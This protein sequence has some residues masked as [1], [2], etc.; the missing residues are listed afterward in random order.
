MKKQIRYLRGFFILLLLMA[1]YQ[2]AY[3]QSIV[4]SDN[5]SPVIPNGEKLEFKIKL[6]PGTP[7]TNCYL[8]AYA[9]TGWTFVGSSLPA[10]QQINATGDTIKISFSTLSATTDISIYLRPGC[11]I[12]DKSQVV[13]EFFDSGDNMLAQTATPDIS[14][15]KY[16]VIVQN[17]PADT[18]M[19]LGAIAYREWKLQENEQSA[20]V[21]GGDLTIRGVGNSATTSSTNDKLDLLILGVEYLTKDS[22]WQPL[23]ATIASDQKSY[24]YTFTSEDFK[25]IGN[26]DSILSYADGIIRIREKVQLSRC[27]TSSFSSITVQP[28]LTYSISHACSQTKVT[29]GTS[30]VTYAAPYPNSPISLVK[31]TNPTQAENMGKTILKL[32]NINDLYYEDI[33]LRLYDNDSYIWWMNIQ[34][35]YFSD[36]NGNI[37]ASA[38]AITWTNTTGDTYLRFNSTTPYKGLVNKTPGDNICDD[39][40]KSSDPIYITLDWYLDLDTKTATCT[41]G[42]S[43]TYFFSMYPY[44][45]MYYNQSPNC[46]TYRTSTSTYL[47][48]TSSTNNY[49]NLGFTAGTGSSIANSNLMYYPEAE[50]PYG[51]RTTITIM[52]APAHTYPNRTFLNDINTYKHTVSLTLPADLKY[53]PDN[54]VTISGIA[55]DPDS[56]WYDEPTRTLTFVNR[57]KA[58]TSTLSYTFTVEPVTATNAADKSVKVSHTID[59]GGTTYR[60]GCYSVPLSYIIYIP[61]ECNYIV[62]DGFRAERT[63][64]GY[65]ESDHSKQMTLAEAHAAGARLDIIGPYDNVEFEINA[66]IKGDS[67]WYYDADRPLYA[68]ISYRM[69]QTNPYFGK[70]QGAILEYKRPGETTWNPAISIPASALIQSYAGTVHRLRVDILPYL[71]SAGVPLLKDTRFRVT[72]LSQATGNLPRVMEGVP[73]FEMGIYADGRYVYDCNIHSSNLFVFDYRVQY[74]TT[75]TTGDNPPTE[76]FWANGDPNHNEIMLL[77]LHM[78]NLDFASNEIFTNEFRPN[79][80]LNTFVWRYGYGTFVPERIW[81]SEGR[82][83]VKDVDYTVT[84]YSYY[85][86]ITFKSDLNALMGEY[87][88]SKDDFATDPVGK[89][90]YY[91]FATAKQVCYYNTYSG[92]SSTVSWY[93]TS[94]APYRTTSPGGDSD[95]YKARSQYQWSISTTSTQSDQKTGSNKLSWPLRLT[96]SSTW[97]STA[98]GANYFMPN[99]YLFL[100]VFSGRLENYELYRVVGGIEQ[101]VNAPFEKYTSGSTDAATG[102][103]KEAYWIKIGNI[104][105]DYLSASSCTAD[106]VLKAKYPDC[107]SSDTI[108]NIKLKAKF[109]VNT[110]EY[111]ADPWQGWTKYAATSC[112]HDGA[113]LALTSAFYAMDFSGTVDA[114]AKMLPGGKF[115]LCDTIPFK[116]SYVNNLYCP[117]GSLEFKVHR[118]SGSSLVLHDPTLPNSLYYMK[119]GT[120]VSYDPSTWFIDESNNDYILIKLPE[121]TILDARPFDILAPI[122]GAQIDL[123]VNLIPTCDFLFGLPIYM[124]V[125]GSS[126]CGLTE[127]KSVATDNIR[128]FG[129]DESNDPISSV[130]VKLNDKTSGAVLPYLTDADGQLKLKGYFRFGEDQA[131]NKASAYIS[132]PPNTRLKSGGTNTFQRTGGASGSSTSFTA[133]TQN[134]LRASFA[135]GESTLTQYDYEVDLEAIN[136]EKWDCREKIITMG[137]TVSVEQKCHPEDLTPCNVNNSIM[138]QQFKFTMQK[139][140]VVLVPDSVTLVESY[141][142]VNNREKLSV[143]IG[144]K[145]NDAVSIDNLKLLLYQDVLPNGYGSEDRRIVNAGL[146]ITC[147]VAGKDSLTFTT[148]LTVPATD[149]C[150]LMVVL[151]RYGEPNKFL[152]DSMYVKP[153]LIYQYPQTAFKV[154]QG[155]TLILGDPTIAGYKYEWATSGGGQ[156]IEMTPGAGLEQGQVKYIFPKGLSLTPSGQTQ[157]VRVTLTRNA[158]LGGITECKADDV[159]FSV[160]IVPKL[161][162]WIGG[163]NTTWE[164][165]YNW[166]QGVPDK[167]TYV[168]IPETASNY[169]IL[170]WALTDVNSAKCDTIEFLNG[171]EV[172]KTHLLDYN[173]AKVRLAL[174]SDRWYMISSPLRYM[175]T[176]DYY[177]DGTNYIDKPGT[178]IYDPNTLTWGRT[179]DVYWM[180]YRMRNPE[181]Y[182]YYSADLYW[183]YPFN[184]L[185]QTMDPGKGL[186][187]W[188]DLETNMNVDTDPTHLKSGRNAPADKKARFTFPRKE[189]SY[190]YYNGIGFNDPKYTGTEVQ[191]DR[192]LDPNIY[193]NTTVKWQT[194]L[195]RGGVANSDSLRSRFGYEGLSDFNLTAGTFTTPVYVNDQYAATAMV[196]NPF[197]SHLSLQTFRSA[198]STM[199]N[200]SFYVWSSTS[201]SF[202]ALKLSNMDVLYSTSSTY[203]IAPMQSF[204]VTRYSTTP[205]TRL[206]FNAN[207]MSVTRPTDKLRSGGIEESLNLSIYRNGIRQSAVL[208]LYDENAVNAFSDNKDQYTLFP[209]EKTSPVLYTLTS[210]GVDRR[211]LSI[212]TIGDLTDAIPLGIRTDSKGD[213]LSM[214]LNYVEDSEDSEV[215]K[216]EEDEELRSSGS[217]MSVYLEDTE[218]NTLY[219][220]SKNPEYIFT[221]FAGNITEGR[222]YLRFIDSTTDIKDA[223]ANEFYIYASNGHVYVYSERD[224][225]TNVEAFNLQGQSIYKK[226]GLNTEYHSFDLYNHENQVII[227]RVQTRDGVKSKK[228]LMK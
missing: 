27:H 207:T 108:S 22:G 179:P 103:A 223:Q 14:N 55:V 26:K 150:N 52:D 159:N 211:A 134:Y 189:N 63:S 127:T 214:R 140:N 24:T 9:P 133:I 172:S 10:Q 18:T 170:T 224:L 146:P 58:I 145:N 130:S 16:P 88:R 104:Y 77:N 122:A 21:I 206:N 74:S 174:N 47:L 184:I 182:S 137:V 162:Q 43:S 209:V 30:T 94:G 139:R 100:E 117:V 186:M 80:V 57:V 149:I 33:Y 90:A 147:T 199:L 53:V 188:P 165:P 210:T 131:N 120:K 205:F 144:V 91:I 8:K 200:T 190:Y 98:N 155:D 87:Y 35:V 110:V 135:S 48:A 95:I 183:S 84:Y 59:W 201:N 158:G 38:P 93:P 19:R 212:Y 128:L 168:I 64:V 125:T 23:A 28:K 61:G 101:K 121:A 25:K 227:V 175:Y 180:Y 213:L 166:T 141:D 177:V 163:V 113:T 7:F 222:F 72:L 178:E 129:Y 216:P 96:N 81:D 2:G 83:F 70:G 73:D 187:V 196:G 69:L 191:G 45:Y 6:A 46:Y 3:G 203:V 75:W 67:L 15:I 152:C 193:G 20:Y 79:G 78:Q 181:N 111:P 151:P 143:K 5:P 109:A 17:A 54:G 68:E 32:Q 115:V 11:N 50:P 218:S 160:Y 34:N 226:S 29:T 71:K 42:T 154:C 99:T 97:V 220:L 62:A 13:Y 60:Y 167:C 37:D 164:N 56:I 194:N 173:A 123:Y 176:G 92:T 36:I 202:D 124:D 51:S 142:Y 65:S 82:V 126:L 192:A 118:S 105:G 228:V 198:N 107:N 116:V 86:T 119:N 49:S 136:P 76:I 89:Q 85:T 44:Y 204:I 112:Y 215:K 156:L 153:E 185:D 157:Y 1:F 161:S 221:N 195:P 102:T 41:T 132:L 171:G 106:F 12:I 225:I 169:P 114:S 138:S 197:M 39:L 219:N 148:N 31:F 217:F 4:T 40:E 208:F 66:Y